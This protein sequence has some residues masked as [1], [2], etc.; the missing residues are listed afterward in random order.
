[1][2]REREPGP[3]YWP[4]G[5]GCD[6]QGELLI[7]GHPAHS[8][9][10]QHGTPLYVYDAEDTG[11]RI[12]ALRSQLPAR[13]RLHYAVRANPYSQLLHRMAPWLDG[14][15]V[16][17]AGELLR[18][19]KAGIS[20][21]RISFAGPAKTT[22]DVEA[23]AQSGCVVGIESAGQ[24]HRVADEARTAG[25]RIPVSI[26]VRPERYLRSDRWLSDSDVPPLGIDASAIPELL[27]EARHLPVYIA[28]FEVRI[29]SANLRGDRIA[30]AH[31]HAVDQVR[32]LCPAGIIPEFVTLAGGFG[33]PSSA[34]DR[35]LDTAVVAQGLGQL[36]RDLQEQWPETHLVLELGRYLVGESGVYLTRVVE[37][38]V[39]GGEVF[40][41]TDGGTH[42]RQTAS[43]LPGADGRSDPPVA[44]ATR[45]NNPDTETVSILGPLDSPHDCLAARVPLPHA[46]PGD[47]IAVFLSG[48]Y[49]LTASPAG[50]QD[51]PLPAEIVL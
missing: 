1:M 28:G 31:R 26:H 39:S 36:A 25:H 46:E 23:A 21:S 32:S 15:G 33:I 43:G 27:E 50:F 47:L 9:A 11:E 38:K 30:E 6:H 22:E 37:R 3:Y 8:L 29:G 19:R 20:P 34:E 5:L 18:A 48:A 14:M 2:T 35:P 40:L 44:I 13:V 16:V 12:Q 51:R 10:E 41:L 17:S 24:L 7:A 4:P 42:H 49:G 45:V